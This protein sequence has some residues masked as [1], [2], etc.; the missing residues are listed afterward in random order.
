MAAT[1]VRWAG[2][3]HRT[4]GNTEAARDCFVAS[5]AVARARGDLSDVAH[6]LNWL[7][8]ISQD[9]GRLDAADRLF[10]RARTAASR[11]RDLRTLAM[12]EHNLGI[13][14]NIRGNLPRA[15]AHYRRALAWYSRL[16][17]PRYFAQ[18]LNELGMLYTDLGRWQ[19]ARRVFARGAR[20]AAEI[21]DLHT[22]VM[23]ASNRTELA[24]ARGAWNE[25][26]SACGRAETLAQRLGQ[27]GPHGEV[28]R[29]LGVIHRESGASAEAEQALKSARSIAQDQ[30]IP[31]LEA[32]AEREL[33]GLFRI[34]E[35]NREALESLLASRRIYTQLRAKR[36][37]AELGRRL[38]QIESQFLDVVQAWAESIEAKDRYT[39]GHCGR[40]ADLATALARRLGLE[41][42]AL[43]WF[44]MGAFLH[45]VG[46]TETPTEILNKP[47]PLTEVEA[48]VV[49]R[50][51]VAG[52]SIVTALD[53]PW[54]IRPMVRSHHERWDGDGYPDGLRGREI[55]LTAR[56]LCVVDVFDALTSDR[57]Y[58]EA[59]SRDQAMAIMARSSG[60]Q[61][62]PEVFVTFVGLTSET[63]QTP[64]RRS[65]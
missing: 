41:D 52:D 54:D 40:V 22:S 37:L 6:A 13:N 9:R 11:A 29:W 39:H 30:G 7:G 20:L 45:D 3:T 15:L 44:R 63:A 2:A 8:I 25:A 47:G 43:M 64:L 28:H 34:Q 53:F 42:D 46:K 60:S 5:L 57:P 61:F 35:R 1:I 4:E 18:G 49:R 55:P 38:K 50:H 12:I 17:E 56:I 24:V 10:G 14:C 26:R 27:E 19:A 48:E 51:T 36:D 62:D 65:A 58:R 23:I 16:K 32:E 21:G 59:L 31:L 33:A